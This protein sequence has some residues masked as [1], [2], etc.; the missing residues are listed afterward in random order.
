MVV[1]SPGNNILTREQVFAAMPEDKLKYSSAKGT[2][3]T[4]FVSQD[5]AVEMAMKT[6]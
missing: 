2:L 6:S 1:N 5:L 4:L 3:E